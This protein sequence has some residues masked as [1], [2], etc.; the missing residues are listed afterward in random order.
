[1]TSIIDWNLT[2]KMANNKQDFAEE[3]LF[4]FSKALPAD[5]RAIS[6]A[7]ENRDYIALSKYLHKLEGATC[8]CG[9]PRLR[10]S[11]QDLQRALKANDLIILPTLISELEFEAM[12]VIESVTN[13]YE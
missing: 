2:L 13:D 6:L 1:M 8:Y 7:E 10:R 11:I 5:L 3:M 12:H 4:L 9:V